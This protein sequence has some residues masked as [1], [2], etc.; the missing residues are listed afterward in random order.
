MADDCL[1]CKIIAGEIPSTKV[2]EDDTTY[3]FNDLNPKA[4]VHVLVVPKKHYA[5]VAELAK[6]DP[7]ELA[8][9]VEVAQSIADKE[10]HGAFRLIFNSGKDAGQSV[11][12]VHAHVLTGETMEE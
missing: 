11:F 5:N 6:A 4:K 2:Y 9:I 7:A 12:H 3:A 10:F 8:H 1:F